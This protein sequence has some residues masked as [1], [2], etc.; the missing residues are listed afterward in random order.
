M[1][2]NAFD[3]ASKS[4]N[5]LTVRK[6][7]SQRGPNPARVD[8]IM[9]KSKEIQFNNWDPLGEMLK[10]W[11]EVFWPRHCIGLMLC[12]R[13]LLFICLRHEGQQLWL[14]HTH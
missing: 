14:P 12:Q 2:L 11:G 13:K 6:D 4:Q 5:L 1:P 10:F 7:R 8:S 3:L 9:Q